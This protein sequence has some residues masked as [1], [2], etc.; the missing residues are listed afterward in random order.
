[1]LDIKFIRENADLVREAARKKHVDFKVE[2]LLTADDER[3][4]ILAEVENL[5]HQQKE[6]GRERAPIEELKK[7]KTEL[8][9]KEEKLKEVMRTWQ[10]L[11]LAVPNVPDISVP[12][13]ASDADNQELRA[14]GEKPKFNFEPKNHV[15][16]MNV[17]GWL[18]LER[19]TKIAGFR[20]YVL[21]RD[22]VKINFALWQLA[23]DFFSAKDFVP[24]MVP[25]LV[26]K[27]ML[28]GSGYL[29]QGEED[30][31]KTQ[32]DDYL[33][34][35]GEV[36]ALG[37]FMGDVIDQHKLPLKILAFSP[38][39]RREAGS[40]GKDTKGL[41]RVHEFFKWEL[42]ILCEA[43]H[44]VSVRLHEEL[45]ANSEEF[46]QLL[47]IPYHVV[48]NC[49]ADLGLGQVK[50]YDIEAWVPS[51]RKYRETHS[52]SYFHDFQ[53]R[54]L[55]IKYKDADGKLRFAHTLNNTALPTPRLLVP[56]IENNQQADGTVKLPTVLEKYLANGAA[57]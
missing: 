46:V 22:L 48:T 17:L 4:E 7:L 8:Q 37:Y 40:H 30:L 41:V 11:M 1:M 20:G 36:G 16:L 54:R 2:E 3:L 50:K 35:T 47:E 10:R 13:G 52:A 12:E 28:V 34:G 45:L 38:C 39:Y 9:N 33:A 18:D 32:D 56:L 29:P 43:S 6:G 5:R 49:G 19:G 14:W 25:S 44:E 55:N 15:D 53:S 23:L 24:M 27:E 31:Y 57:A 51:E 42:L 21:Q 26:R